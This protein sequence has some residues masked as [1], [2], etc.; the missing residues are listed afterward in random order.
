MGKI[1]LLFAGQ[2]A[3]HPGMGKEL[4]HAQPVAKQ[5]FDE[6]ESAMPGLSKLCF[7]GTKEELTR[8]ENTQP[9]IFA[10]DLAAA[11]SLVARGIN[12]DGVAGFCQDMN[13]KKKA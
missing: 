3:Q 11:R 10:T 9:A 7:E 13:P 12:P 4:V 2:G 6:L 1:A 8:T 5:T